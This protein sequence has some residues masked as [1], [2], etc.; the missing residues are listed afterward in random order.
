MLALTG[1][2]L[3][4]GKGGEPLAGATVLVGDDGRIAAAGPGAAVVVPEGA[5]QVDVTGKTVL[6]GLIDCHDHLASFTYD[7]ASRWGYAEPASTRAVRI[8][9][10]MEATLRTGYTTV[11][12]CGWLDGGFKAAVNEGIVDGPRLLVAAGPLSPTHGT[13]DRPT[14]SGYRRTNMPDPNIPYGI[15]DGVD[16][17]RAAVR[18]NVRVGAD[19]IK[20]FQTG[21]GNPTHGD[22][23]NAYSLEELK[24]LVDE[25]HAQGRRVACHAI[26]GPGLRT[27]VEAGVDSI[28]HGC[29]L[30]LEPD[31]LKMMADQNTYLAPTLTVFT[32]HEVRG[33][34]V[35]QAESQ[36]FKHH[37]LETVQKA[38]AAG[39]KVVAGTDAGGWEHG[40]NSKELE[41]LVAAGMTPM[42]AL[43]AGTSWAAGCLGLEDSLGTVEAGKLAD[44]VVVDGD[45]LADITI[46]Q[47][48]ERVQLVMKEGRIYHDQVSGGGG[49]G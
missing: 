25:S 44:I 49:A 33:N 43:M 18:E 14:P 37:H 2:T 16:G 8:G 5:R 7:L 35:A 23:D 13:Q 6:P 36:A 29:Y 30:D 24:A 17:V 11:R 40:N 12:D 39:V 41:L 27:S 26:G 1:G 45:P 20:V 48:N 4:D 46:L 32:F 21:F 15:A 10:V 42:Q 3:I 47:N 28:E 9:R 34:P 19:L 31:L 38:L 22:S